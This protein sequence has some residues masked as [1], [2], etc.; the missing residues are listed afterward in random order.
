M[1][2]IKCHDCGGEVSSTAEKCPK[3]GAPTPLTV[4]A[5]VIAMIVAAAAL[6]AIF[7]VYWA[8]YG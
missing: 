2:L 5:S 3:C 1:A 7:F 4:N 6:L 8:V